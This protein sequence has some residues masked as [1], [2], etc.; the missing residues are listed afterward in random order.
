MNNDPCGCKTLAH[1]M[2]DLFEGED[3]RVVECAMSQV[4]AAMLMQ[5]NNPAAG[6]TEFGY[7]LLSHMSDMQDMP[8]MGNA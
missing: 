1:K 3:F 4:L 8:T 6:M 7:R 2:A 5:S